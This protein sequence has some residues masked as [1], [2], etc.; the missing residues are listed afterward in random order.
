M[1]TTLVSTSRPLTFKSIGLTVLAFMLASFTVQA[2]SHFFLNTAH[3]SSVSFM[4]PEPIMPL[5][6]SVMILQGIILGLLFPAI[7]W[8]GPVKRNALLFS[9]LMGAF[10]GAYIAFVEP[11]KY[12]VPSVGTW[13][14]VEASASLVQFL[15]FGVLLGFI[16][17]ESKLT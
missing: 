8:R 10:L 5:G 3:Y 15:I 11:A 14:C 12:A 17:R 6:L 1:A 7:K 13:I 16:H 9:L 2:G 4:R